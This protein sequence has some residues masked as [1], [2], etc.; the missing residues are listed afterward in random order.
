MFAFNPFS[1]LVSSLSQCQNPKMNNVK[2]QRF[3]LACFRGLGPG[4]LG[5][6]SWGL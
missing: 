1:V 2:D 5:T 6:V 3:I 4:S